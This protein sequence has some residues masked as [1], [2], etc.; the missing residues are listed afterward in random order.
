MV[1]H[2]QFVPLS[3]IC[4]FHFISFNFLY[5]THE[6]REWVRFKSS[7]AISSIFC[8]F[9]H[10]VRSVHVTK[11]LIY[12]ESFTCVSNFIKFIMSLMRDVFINTIHFHPYGI[13]AHKTMFNLMFFFPY[14]FC[15]SF[16]QRLKNIKKSCFSK[17]KFN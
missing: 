17:C 2:H 10:K 3:P 4:E 5:V 1:K 9:I 12:V 6:T 11:F 16:T 14:K 8:N 13:C 7:R 15:Y